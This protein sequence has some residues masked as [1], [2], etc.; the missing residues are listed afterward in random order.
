MYMCG[1]LF[2]PPSYISVPHVTN[3]MW[4]LADLINGRKN[5]RNILSIIDVCLVVLECDL[6]GNKITS[7]PSDTCV[8]SVK[9]VKKSRFHESDIADMETP[10]VSILYLLCDD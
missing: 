8:F 7:K 1:G 2:R 9:K 6:E 4:Y 10:L 3:L 5:N